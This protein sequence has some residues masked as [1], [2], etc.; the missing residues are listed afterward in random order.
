MS[1][2]SLHD[3]ASSGELSK[4][5]EEQLQKL[6]NDI[7][8]HIRTEQQFRLHIESLTSKNEELEAELE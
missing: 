8:L 6:E 5:H 7:R 2:N 4:E 3:L 1:A